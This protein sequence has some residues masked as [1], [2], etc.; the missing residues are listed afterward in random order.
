MELTAL[1]SNFKKQQLF[2]KKNIVVKFIPT[3]SLKKG[4]AGNRN[5][6][7]NTTTGTLPTTGI[8]STNPY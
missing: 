2:L 1:T 7:Y 8:V 3:N 6:T 5:D 4:L